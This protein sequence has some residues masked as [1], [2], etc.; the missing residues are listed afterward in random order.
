MENNDRLT[1][2]L[3]TGK[4]TYERILS[5][6]TNE[7]YR[8]ISPYW[9]KRLLN[10]SALKA[11]YKSLVFRR[12]VFPWHKFD[13]CVEYPR[14]FSK[15]CIRNLNTGESSEFPFESIRFGENNGKQVFVIRF[16][17]A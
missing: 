15:V 11:D 10:Y 13:A 3:T 14:G 9:E 16:T 8:P 12:C 4:D 1:L 6:Q 17:N 5:G 7:V 2:S